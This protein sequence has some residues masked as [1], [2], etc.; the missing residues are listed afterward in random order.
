MKLKRI[1]LT[2]KLTIV[3]IALG[4]I[5]AAAVSATAYYLAKDAL[6]K[7]TIYQLTTVKSVKKRHIENFFLGVE[8]D[9]HFLCEEYNRVNSI[10]S[11][12]LSL[13]M[14]KQF[15]DS[16]EHYEDFC[17]ISKNG[18][19][20]YGDCDSSK[21][22]D[23][24][25]FL[26][27]KSFF[28]KDMSVSDSGK[29]SPLTAG[30]PLGDGTVLTLEISR[31][32]VNKIMLEMSSESGLGESGESYLVGPD[33]LMRSDSRFIEKTTMKT[34]VRSKAVA[35]ALAGE[36]GSD[37]IADY[38]EV[39]VFSAFG[40]IDVA[41]LDWAILAEIDIRE[42]LAPIDR[43]RNYTL[44]LTIS[45]SLAVFI[46]AYMISKRISKPLKCLTETARKI[47]SG[48]LGAQVEIESSDEIGELAEAFNIMSVSLKAKS[49]ELDKERLKKYSI[50]ADARDKERE[51]VS[52]ELHD[53]VGQALIAIKLKFERAL[54]M[55]RIDD[56]TAE[57][58]EEAFDST[59]DEIRRI[60]NDLTPPAL[61]AFGLETAIKRLGDVLSNSSGVNFR[62]ETEFSGDLKD[63][64]SKIYLFR[65]VQEALNNIQ[66]HARA[67]NVFVNIFDSGENLNIFIQD[68][69][70]GCD[71][72]AAM[73]NEGAGLHN[74]RERARILGGGAAF[75][76]KPGEG[77]K[78][79]VAAPRSV[80]I[81]DKKQK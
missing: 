64:K 45:I 79:A 26:R 76:S 69:G 66:K 14:L 7:R 43:I 54:N 40:K 46:A 29:I 24:S 81:S 48:D 42:A 18:E 22:A 2:D 3:F 59:I 35:S 21:A 11:P 1:S 73:K 39:E 62:F 16:Y 74:I 58:I 63:K 49:E 51:R 20:I 70:I 61:N 71:I 28:I 72:E 75:D 56:K 12:E 57:D 77:M 33:S 65:I 78:I 50:D 67:K 10:S 41:G 80:V 36:V 44:F 13:A 17:I 31:E 23:L 19:I 30:A 34:A 5:V 8:K 32:A 25:H 68:D 15:V 38:R 47:G 9:I 55:E 53:G 4:A 27:N 52:R 37:R 6:T 60:S